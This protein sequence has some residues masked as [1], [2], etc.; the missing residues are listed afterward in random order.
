[1]TFHATPGNTVL[2]LGE[3]RVIPSNSGYVSTDVCLLVIK[4]DCWASAEVCALLSVLLVLF[5]D[6]IN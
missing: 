3:D 4:E 1:L 6:R 5:C 2:G